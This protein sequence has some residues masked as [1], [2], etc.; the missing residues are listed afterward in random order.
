MTETV[1][2]ALDREPASNKPAEAGPSREGW[3]LFTDI[4]PEDYF[5][6][7]CPVVSLSNSGMRYLL[8]E[9]PLDFAYQNPRLNPDAVDEVKKTAAIYRGDVVHQLALGK[10]RGFAI[11]E[12]KD[13][14]TKA[15][16]EF[17]DAA[18]ADGLTPI[19]REKFE[20]AEIMAEVIREKIK[21]VLDGADY[22]TEVVFMYQEQTAAGPIWVRG[23]LD[24]WCPEKAVIL[25]PKVTPMLYD[26]KVERQLLNMGW[27]RQASLYPH[28]VG[29]ILPQLAGRVQF[30]DLM[31]K[32]TEPFT[33]RLVGL[34][35]SWE[36]SSIQECKRAMEIFGECVHSGRWPGFGDDIHRVDL[37][38]WEDKRRE[39]R[40][41][42]EAA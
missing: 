15:A 29:M 1:F 13:W 3:G 35:K 36:Y 34:R 41:L 7:P 17:K 38:K 42:G 9:T 18:I 31:V 39:E 21:R 14:R 4:K 33:S 40:A 24:V 26:G 10:G 8:E 37:P 28:A 6:D 23:M 22:Q 16:G 11:G 32:P 5:L 27:D 25:D 30:A 19:L 12:F 2:D 20:E